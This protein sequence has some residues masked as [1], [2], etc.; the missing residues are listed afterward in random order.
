VVKLIL[1]L[2]NGVTV[3]LLSASF[4]HVKPT[5]HQII[6]GVGLSF[7]PWLPLILYVGY[8]GWILAAERFGITLFLKLSG[9]L[10][11]RIVTSILATSIVAA[12]PYFAAWLGAWSAL[13]IAPWGEEFTALC[14]GLGSGFFA[15]L[16]LAP[17]LWEESPHFPSSSTFRSGAKEARFREA[18][19]HIEQ[20]GSDSPYRPRFGGILLTKIAELSNFLCVGLPNSG[21]SKIIQMLVRSLFTAIGRVPDHRAIA[22]DYKQDAITL[23]ESIGVKYK[24]FCPIHR[25]SSYWDIQHEI[26][27]H[28]QTRAI[29][30]I[31][32]PLRDGSQPYFSLSVQDLAS[33]VIKTRMAQSEQDS[34]FQWDLFSIIEPMGNPASLKELFAQSPMGRDLLQLYEKARSGGDV[35]ATARTYAGQLASAAYAMRCLKERGAEPF[36]IK[37]WL[38]DNGRQNYV[39][40]LGWDT[41]YGKVLERLSQILIGRSIQLIQRLPDKPNERRIYYLLDEFP[42]LG[43]I[44]YITD[45]L[46]GCRSKG[47]VVIAGLQFYSSL[48]ALY[49][50]NKAA[51]IL[52]AFQQKGYTRQGAGTAARAEVELGL[53]EIERWVPSES[54]NADGSRQESRQL[55]IMTEPVLRKE[56]LQHLHL[57][58]P[59][60]G[61]TAVCTSV[62]LDSSI[63]T[64]WQYTYS[65]AE[66]ATYAPELPLYQIEQ[67]S[68]EFLNAENWSFL[69]DGE[70][71]NAND[72][73]PGTESENDF[74]E[75][76]AFSFKEGGPLPPPFR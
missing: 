50:E 53:Q 40:I 75:D 64:F 33:G 4:P 24:Y 56:K 20:K 14:G 42:R 48:I 73:S 37:E 74:P 62:D 23:M 51:S 65:G 22:F 34:S 12:T 44:P 3:A 59:L 61:L 39:L 76:E 45:L 1:R 58:N 17:L 60:R 30:E 21:K 72:N 28:E 68:S 70:G 41:E 66:V 15:V 9:S 46:E 57:P 43:I 69:A 6:N 63:G 18:K 8:G 47:V 49:G 67:V 2:V 10:K 35:S 38:K 7:L 13:Q 54:R 31:L 55:Q 25:C 26:K 52:D 19:E 71:D 29:A 36:T 11:R 27:D 5:L 16:L 32:F